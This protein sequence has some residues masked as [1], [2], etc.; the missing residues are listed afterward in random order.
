MK[1][2]KINI[3]SM[4]IKSITNLNKQITNRQQINIHFDYPL[5]NK[6]IITYNRST[7]FTLNDI[8]ICIQDGYESIYKKPTKY[9]I[10]GHGLSDLYLEG[11]TMKGKDIY[12]SVG[13]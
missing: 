10:W 3:D 9:G 8:I 5:D 6:H 2:K 4:H 1:T 11:I 7:G 12:L 13:S